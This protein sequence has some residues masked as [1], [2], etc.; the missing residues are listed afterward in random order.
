MTVAAAAT[1]RVE[2][3]NDRGWGQTL[4]N[5]RTSGPKVS[6]VELRHYRK[7]ASTFELTGGR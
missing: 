1:A 2:E 4:A 5:I 7:Q 3:E 6:F